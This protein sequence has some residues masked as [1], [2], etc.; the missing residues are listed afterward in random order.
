MLVKTVLQAIISLLLRVQHVCRVARVHTLIFQISRLE[1]HFAQTALPSRTRLPSA[2][3]LAFAH[4]LRDLQVQMGATVRRVNQDNT[5][6]SLAP[7][8][9]KTVHWDTSCPTQ[10]LLH[11]MPVITIHMQISQLPLYV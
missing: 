1:R 5:K 11:V 3:T 7:R 6:T 8:S 10:V 2:P 4:A 9:A